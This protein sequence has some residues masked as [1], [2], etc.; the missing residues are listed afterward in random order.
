MAFSLGFEIAIV[1]VADSL[2]RQY[3]TK[4]KILYKNI[5]GVAENVPGRN[6]AGR[7]I[8]DELLTYTNVRKQV[9]VDQLKSFS[10]LFVLRKS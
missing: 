5:R 4:E 9:L 8:L 3:L 10:Y 2:L 6:I 1:R 7:K